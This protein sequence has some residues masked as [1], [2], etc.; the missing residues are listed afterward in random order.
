MQQS[1]SKTNNDQP[2][3]LMDLLPE[4][5]SAGFGSAMLRL[6]HMA[7]AQHRAEVSMQNV[8]PWTG[9]TVIELDS[10]D[11]AGHGSPA[12]SRSVC[13]SGPVTREGDR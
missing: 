4:F 12:V 5:G 11:K 2:M 10:M 8:K 9:L 6:A 3:R 1:T 7:A 13:E